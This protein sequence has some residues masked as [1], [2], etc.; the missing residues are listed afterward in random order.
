V[1]STCRLS[2]STVSASI[3]LNDFDGDI[4]LVSVSGEITAVCGAGDAEVSSVSGE[5]SLDC[6]STNT[7]IENVSGDVRLTGASGRLS[8]STVSGDF[9]ISGGTFS[10]INAE[11]VSG[12]LQFDC[13]L[14]GNTRVEID[15]HSGDVIFLL[16]AAPQVDISVDTF[17]GGIINE[18]GMEGI[19]DEYSKGTVLWNAPGGSGN[20]KIEINTFSGEVLLKQK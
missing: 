2:V 4:E 5:I 8:G 13:E 17:S 3:D 6:Q 9:L 16:S 15:S 18:F 12:D 1:P 14:D 20:G 10:D 11:T 19:S 7:E